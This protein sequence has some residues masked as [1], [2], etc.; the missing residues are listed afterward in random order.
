MDPVLSVMFGGIGVILG[1]IVSAVQGSRSSIVTSSK[2]AVDT[3][4]ETLKAQLTRVENMDTQI[5]SQGK[6]I[7][8]LNTRVSEITRNHTV[9]IHHIADREDAAEEFLGPERPEWLPPV[10]EL[11]RPDVDAAR[12]TH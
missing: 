8:D 11:I 9:A 1:S 12:L 6:L 2:A 3:M 10:P 4:S 7:S 5:T